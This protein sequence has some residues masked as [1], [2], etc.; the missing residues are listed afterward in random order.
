MTFIFRSPT[1]F[2]QFSLIVLTVTV[3]VAGATF[4]YADGPAPDELTL[5]GAFTGLAPGEKRI[6]T[7]AELRALPGVEHRRQRLASNL[8]ESDVEILPIAALLAAYPVASGADMLVLRSND[9]WHSYWTRDFMVSHKPWLLLAVNG[10]TPSEGEWPVIPFNGEPFAPYHA[11]I[12]Q[13]GDPPGMTYTPA[14]GVAD[15]TQVVEIIAV[16]EAEH[17]AP[18]FSGPQASLSPIAAEGRRLFMANCIT[19]HQG[20]GGVGGN[21]SR[22]PFMILQTHASYNADYFRKF[23]ANAKQFMPETI[24]PPHSQF[25]DADFRALIA[26]LKAIPIEPPPAP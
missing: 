8:P 5:T 7:R 25:T 15:A 21:L 13:A 18:F 26:Y 11:G 16:N 23:V 20:P 3:R 19:C 17:F 10:K 24:M 1:R 6:V 14:H 4:A 22:R 2:F 12:N 9:R